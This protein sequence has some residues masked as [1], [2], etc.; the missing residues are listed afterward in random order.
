MGMGSGTFN[1]ICPTCGSK[2]YKATYTPRED[3]PNRCNV[4]LSCD[5]CGFLFQIDDTEVFVKR[6]ES[7]DTVKEQ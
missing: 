7:V 3:N 5:D 4:V 2:N 1:G 6:A